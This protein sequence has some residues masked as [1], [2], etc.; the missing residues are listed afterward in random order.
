MTVNNVLNMRCGGRYIYVF[1]LLYPVLYNS[2]FNGTEAAIVANIICINIY[3]RG[4]VGHQYNV[5]A[6]DNA[7]KN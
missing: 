2:Y 1:S 4:I 6:Y 5:L 3:G 7:L